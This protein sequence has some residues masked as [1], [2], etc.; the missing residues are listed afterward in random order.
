MNTVITVIAILMVADSLFT[1]LNLSKV[2]SILHNVFP[3]LNIKKL[4]IIEGFAG[5][6][7]LLFKVSTNSIS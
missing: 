6:V 7:I 1:L 2:E 3:S 5:G 4:A